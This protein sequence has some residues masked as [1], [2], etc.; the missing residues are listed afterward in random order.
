MRRTSFIIYRN[1]LEDICAMPGGVA[2]PL[3]L[4]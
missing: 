1:V 3:A 2:P 4:C